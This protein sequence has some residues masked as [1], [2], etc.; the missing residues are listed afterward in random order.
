MFN[1]RFAS[2]SWGG[3]QRARILMVAGRVRVAGAGC[4]RMKC[5]PAARAWR[6]VGGALLALFSAVPSPAAAE[7][8]SFSEGL[9]GIGRPL[10]GTERAAVSMIWLN[11]SES[12]FGP[13]APDRIEQSWQP[14]ESYSS[15]LPGTTEPVMPLSPGPLPI[16]GTFTGDGLS[17][18]FSGGAVTVPS[19][20]PPTDEEGLY[21][22]TTPFSMTG[23]WT[24]DVATSSGITRFDRDVSA[25]G[26]VHVL[27]GAERAT[28][29]SIISQVNYF[30]EDT[31]PVPEPGTIVLLTLGCVS[32]ATRV[33]RRPGRRE[34]ATQPPNRTS[35]DGAASGCRHRT[36]C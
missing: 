28:G 7:P 33:R 19:V 17:L 27:L 36:Q 35:L 20:F 12:I 3:L 24:I 8:V 15:T 11:P 30:F 25:A 6:H 32:L 10:I 16:S 1:A 23:H 34:R 26:I 9:F 2:S 14:F 18:D 13:G 4:V 22:L 21:T 29:T 31:T 5:P